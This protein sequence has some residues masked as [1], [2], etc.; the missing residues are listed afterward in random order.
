[1]P[2]FRPA[3]PVEHPQG[4]LS[5]AMRCFWSHVAGGRRSSAGSGSARRMR[6]GMDAFLSPGGTCA[7]IGS[8]GFFRGS[9]ARRI[10]WRSMLAIGPLV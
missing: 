2:L 9:L 3:P 5:S 6:V 4:R 8:L 10:S 7:L 1:M